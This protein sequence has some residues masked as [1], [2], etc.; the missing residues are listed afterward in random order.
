[1]YK[2]ILVGCG[3]IAPRHIREIMRVGT[4][5][6]VCDTNHERLAEYI[7]LYKVKGFRSF[8]EIWS[9]PVEA[10]IIVL[11]TPNGLHA[12]QSMMALEH[13]CH[14]ICEKPMAIHSK[15]ALAMLQSAKKWNKSLTIVKQNRFNGPIIQLKEWISSG[16]SGQVYSISMNCLWNRSE[17]YYTSS[18]WRGKNDLDGGIL[19]TQ[20]SHYIDFLYW[21]FGEV[22]DIYSLSSNVHHQGVISFADQGV[23]SLKFSSGVLGT[24]HYSINAYEKNMESSLTVLAE[25]GSIRVGGLSC[26]LVEYQQTSVPPFTSH[27]TSFNEYPAYSG[28]SSN[29]HF[30]YDHVLKGLDSGEFDS[31]SAFEAMKTVELIERIYQQAK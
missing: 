25:H 4:L 17:A 28:S 22:S 2:F 21:I 5:A 15:D 27:E 16:A 18:I 7:N 12:S 30:V 14:V 20:F 1:M 31:Q 24:I 26:N 9:V 10:D 23:V 8:E 13:G 6:A 3:S 29:H 19:Y 11:C